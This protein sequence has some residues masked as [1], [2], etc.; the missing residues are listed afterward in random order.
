M[1]ASQG[2]FLVPTQMKNRIS[3]LELIVLILEKFENTAEFPVW[4]IG[5]P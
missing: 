3:D 1:T 4:G 5:R 2:L